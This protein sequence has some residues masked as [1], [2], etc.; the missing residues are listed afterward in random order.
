MSTFQEMFSSVFPDEKQTLS[1]REKKDMLVNHF[2]EKTRKEYDENVE[3]HR[4]KLEAFK[5]TNTRYKEIS[6]EL[7]AKFKSLN[8]LEKEYTKIDREIKSDNKKLNLITEELTKHLQPYVQD[9]NIK[10]VEEDEINELYNRC[11]NDELDDAFDNY[12]KK[13][14]GEKN[15]LSA[16]MKRDMLI[17]YFYDLEKKKLAERKEIYFSQRKEILDN[18]EIYNQYLKSLENLC[19]QSSQIEEAIHEIDKTIKNLMK[20]Q[21]E[22]IEANIDELPKYKSDAKIMQVLDDLYKK[23]RLIGD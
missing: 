8:K 22:L 21:S 3:K 9:E 11:R 1:S 7:K 19:E 12:F 5:Q 4:K 17:E 2:N 14:L 23:D 6:I 13:V 16:R 15:I 20:L 10:L 18:S